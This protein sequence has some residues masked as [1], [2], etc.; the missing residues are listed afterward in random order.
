MWYECTVCESPGSGWA[1]VVPQEMTNQPQSCA[2]ARLLLL[3]EG[4]VHH[5]SNTVVGP[6]APWKLSQSNVLSSLFLESSVATARHC[7]SL[8]HLS[9]CRGLEAWSS[10]PVGALCCPPRLY[11]PAVRSR[12]QCSLCLVHRVWGS[13]TGTT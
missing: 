5:N 13:C 11:R 10:S 12:V 7:D 8:L 6:C 4:C 9:C 1:C 3:E 2:R